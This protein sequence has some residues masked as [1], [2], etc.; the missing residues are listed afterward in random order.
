MRGLLAELPI[1]S[2]R[3]GSARVAKTYSRHDLFLVTL[4]CRLETRF[5]L[6]RQII[7]TSASEIAAILGRPT[8][9]TKAGRLILTFEPTRVAYVEQREIYVEDGL[10]IALAPIISLVDEYLMP[11]SVSIPAHQTEINFGLREVSSGGR[12]QMR[13]KEAL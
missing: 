7:C 11:L 10:V 2:G 13:R 12:L 1:F 3:I 8:E 4:F 9:V 5:G 6:K